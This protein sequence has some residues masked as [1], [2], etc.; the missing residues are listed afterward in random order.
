MFNK[1]QFVE[2]LKNDVIE[3]L[4]SENTYNISFTEMSSTRKELG[5]TCISVSTDVHEYGIIFYPNQLYSLYEEGEVISELAQ[6]IV[7]NLKDGERIKE[8]FHSLYSQRVSNPQN[9]IYPMPVS[10]VDNKELLSECPHQKIEG[11]DLALI[12]YLQLDD[13]SKTKITNMIAADMKLTKEELFSMANNKLNNYRFDSIASLIYSTLNDDAE[14]Q[15]E[16]F[17]EMDL[18]APP[19]YYLT[20]DNGVCFG[21]AAI[22]AN[23]HCLKD[24]HKQLSD[25]SIIPSSK[26]E[27]IIVPDSIGITTDELKSITSTIN[28]DKD[29]IHPSDVLSNTIYHFDGMNLRMDLSDSESIIPENIVDLHKGVHM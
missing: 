13:N 26:N 6:N 11:T 7:D 17:S 8:T 1:N 24:I 28:A 23:T 18:S 14:M 22:I 25:F 4:Q 21:G 27:L 15:K 10:I 2:A 16:L 20:A 3:K 12:Y 5:E 19:L 29:L 9:Y